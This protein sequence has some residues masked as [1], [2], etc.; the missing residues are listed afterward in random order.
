M[1]LLRFVTAAGI[2]LLVTLTLPAFGAA[3]A[4][5]LLFDDTGALWVTTDD[6]V[7]TYQINRG[8]LS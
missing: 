2:A 8:G 7:V 3:T 1:K 5:P 4:R 6:G